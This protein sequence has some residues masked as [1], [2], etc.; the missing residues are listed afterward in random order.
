MRPTSSLA[1]TYARETIATLAEIA[2]TLVLQHM[3]VCEGRAETLAQPS[4]HARPSVS[5]LQ[6][7][8]SKMSEFTIAISLNRRPA[9]VRR[10]L[11]GMRN[12]IR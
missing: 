3:R 4:Q 11:S 9:A 6:Q 10:M 2:E 7:L 1:Q 5:Y 8:C 12:G